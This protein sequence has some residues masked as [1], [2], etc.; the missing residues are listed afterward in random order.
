MD[1]SSRNTQRPAARPAAAPVAHPST[2]QKPNASHAKSSSIGKGVKTLSVVLFVSALVLSVAAIV[3]ISL[4]SSETAYVL[5]DNYQVVTLVD[6]QAYFGKVS[7]IT[8]SY[9]VLNDVY[10]IQ[11]T[12]DAKDTSKTTGSTLIKRGCEVHKPTSAMVIYRDQVNFWENIQT[13]GKVAK[14]IEQFKK[15]NPN[16]Q[17]C[18]KQ[19][20]AQGTSQQTTTTDT[21][22]TKAN[23]TTATTDKTSNTSNT[24]N[25]NN[26]NTSN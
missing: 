23:D 14:A 26:T 12:T 19:T 3:S 22:D 25:T 1:F 16:G 24:T 11:E 17:D 5:K 2:P 20:E 13:D 6:K 4:R 15:E 21:T 9:I 7:K 10:Y 18:S 8:D